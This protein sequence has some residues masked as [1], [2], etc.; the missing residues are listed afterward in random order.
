[1]AGWVSEGEEEGVLV[2][3]NSRHRG[4]QVHVLSL[5]AAWGVSCA[6]GLEDATMSLSRRTAVDR[7]DRSR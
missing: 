4:S 5:K 1:M 3:K 6:E 2:E 7:S